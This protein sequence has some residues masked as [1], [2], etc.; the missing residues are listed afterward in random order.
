MK[1]AMS[2]IKSF[3]STKKALSFLVFISVCLAL[4]GF[5]VLFFDSRIQAASEDN[6][7]DSL[8]PKTRISPERFEEDKAASLQ[9]VQQIKSTRRKLK[10]FHIPKAAGTAIEHVA[11]DQM[12]L[13]WGSCLFNHKPKRTICNYPPSDFEW[14][15]N[16]GWWHLPAQLFPMARSDPYAGAELFAVIRDPFDRLVSEVP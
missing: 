8:L 14:P 3:I 13:P 2:L 16:Y 4:Q 6:T 5:A 9:Y 10:F 12:R 15:R 11:G 7:Q 1:L